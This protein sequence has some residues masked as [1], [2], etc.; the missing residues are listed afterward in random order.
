MSVSAGGLLRGFA[1]VGG[2]TMASRVLGFLRDIL[3]AALLG[4][5]PVAEAFFVAFRLPNMFRRFF[6]EGAF[7]TAFVPLFSKRLEGEGPEAARAFAEDAMAGL[8]TA[9][10]LLTLLAQAAMPWF[11]LALASGFS[12]DPARFETAVLFSRICFP[13]I[14]FI[15][16]AALFS[17]VL[18][19]HQR[20][21]AAAAAPVLLNV[22]LIGALLLAW[23]AGL[24]RGAT[25][26]WAV[27]AAGIAQ[28]AMLA[29]AARRIGMGLALRRPR[30]SPDMRRLVRLGLPA[31][32]AGGVMQV[33]LLVGTQVASYFEGAVGWLWYA[34]RVYQLPLGVVGVAIG[35]VLLPTLSRQVRAGDAAGARASTNRAAEAALA[36]TLPATVALL[37]IPGLIVAV[38]FERGAFGPDDTAATALALAVY[39]LGLP[40]YV[41]QK[42]VQPVYFSREDTATPLRYAVVS[43]AVNAIFAVGLA[44]VIGYLAAAVGTVLAAWANLALLWRG[45]RALGAEIAPDARLRARLWRMLAASL[46]MGGIVLVLV[47]VFGRGTGTPAWLVLTVAVA[48]GVAAYAGIAVAIGAFR[49]GEIRAALG[50]GGK[51]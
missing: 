7:N 12:D 34:D 37:A 28:L 38:L 14:L 10:I 19:A 1:T 24:A 8:A 21:A 35:V 46:A 32:L 33:N 20:F 45:A 16:L 9:L 40:A 48:G 22:I 30:L 3:I 25:L 42:V 44:P 36:L 17:G 18:N 11:V 6:A 2:W 39:A 29:I 51:T 47:E 26:S 4:T 41:L 27:F 15:S 13:Y 43:M 23:W 31:A 5:G 50:R 49:P